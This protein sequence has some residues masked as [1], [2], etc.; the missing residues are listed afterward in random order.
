MT[1]S[2]DSELQLGA[3]LIVKEGEEASPLP[4]EHT[5]VRAA[6]QGGLVQVKVTQRFGNPFDTSVELDYLF[7]LPHEAA[8]VDYSI[9]I[10]DRHIRADI[11]EAEAA[12]RTFDE[13]AARGQRRITGTAAA[14]HLSMRIANVQPGE[15]IH[16]EVV[17]ED[18]LKFEDTQYTFTFPMGITPRYHSPANP[19][20]GGSVDA[21]Y[22][23]D[24]SRVGPVEIAVTLEAGIPVGDPVSPSHG[25]R[26]E[27]A[28]EGKFHTTLEGRS[29]P[30]KDFVLRYE[31]AGDK[32]Q[33]TLWT[34]T[35]NEGEIA[36]LTLIPPRLS[37][38]FSAPPR[39][40]LFVIDR[41]GSMSTEPMDQARRALKAC[42]RALN[43]EDTFTI[44]AFDDQIEWF[45]A[46]HALPVTQDHVDQADR[47]LDGIKSRGG[48]E[49]LPAIDAALALK[50]DQS[51]GRYLV[52][53]TD[54]SVSADEAAIQKVAR[55]AG[56]ARMFT[57]GIGP[58]V[59][60]YLLNKIAQ[61]GRGAAAFIGSHEPIEPV[62]AKFQDR[63]SYPALRDLALS[64]EGASLWDTYPA[65]LPDLYVG[66]PL[67]IATR[68]TRSDGA[69]LQLS[70]SAS[71]G[72]LSFKLPL[73]VPQTSDMVR[74]IWARARVESLLDELAAKP[75]QRETIRQQVIALALSYR[76]MTPFTSFVAVDSEVTTG[77]EAK[78][79]RVAL[80][81]SEGLEWDSFTGVYAAG[82][83][84]F[85][86]MAAP[87]SP[88]RFPRAMSMPSM[89][90]RAAKP[91]D[92]VL[93]DALSME[94]EG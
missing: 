81:L 6:I 51:R 35:D 62:I 57:F 30:N 71:G 14:Q 82:G 72:S 39:E 56:A 36:L 91:E 37:V 9:R 13:A 79:V 88:P 45:Y 61:F 47:W 40:F 31:A 32:I 11:R 10:G 18:R 17:Y 2:G 70:G 52:F 92:D 48:T 59:N 53:L 64:G 54:G 20:E 86:M 65:M 75:G 4:L 16:T 42:L 80:P 5:D 15:T 41:S 93:F 3:L 84:G 8:V 26:V 63:V 66:Q 28:G 76:L 49:I 68:L 23:L 83:A 19:A 12:R 50:P 44:Q 74:R 27:R 55:K 29:I 73:P 22:T 67:E 33:S 69:T 34:T 87:G 58:S 1:P 85:A 78:V 77:G 43:P 90:A 7:P 46:N 24:D 38:D 89:H 21:A 25:I 94:Y 60:R